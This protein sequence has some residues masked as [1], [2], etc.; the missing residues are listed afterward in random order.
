MISA[1]QMQQYTWGSGG[2]G[3]SG[4]V[5]VNPYGSAVTGPMTTTTYTKGAKVVATREAEARY[6]HVGIKA[7]YI[8]VVEDILSNDDIAING[9]NGLDIVEAR[10]FQPYQKTQAAKPSKI[11]DLKKLEPLVVTPE[12]RE[13]ITAVLKQQQ[14]G[15]KMFDDWGLGEVIEY[16]KGMTFMFGT[17]IERYPDL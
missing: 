14:N 11:F 8:A 9:S 17:Y 4:A 12:V 15:K 13:E 1:Q 5:V 2:T 7:G 6:G 16:G 10:Y 3:S